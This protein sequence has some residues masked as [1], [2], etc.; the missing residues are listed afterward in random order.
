MNTLELKEMNLSELNESNLTEIE[1]GAWP[2][3][4]KVSLTIGGAGAAGYLVGR[5]A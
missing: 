2:M 4:L 3:W 5:Y 1:G